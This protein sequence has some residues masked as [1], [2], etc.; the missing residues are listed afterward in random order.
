MCCA[1]DGREKLERFYMVHNH[2]KKVVNYGVFRLID[3]AKKYDLLASKY[4]S[5]IAK[6]MTA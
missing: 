1:R 4:I 5:K 2:F 3:T 6:N